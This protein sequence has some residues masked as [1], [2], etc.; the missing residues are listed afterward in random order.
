VTALRRSLLVFLCAAVPALGGNWPAW[1]GPAGDGHSSEKD[2]PLKW[3]ATENVRWKVP[4]PDEGNS[5][6]IVWSDRV[7]LTQATEKA[8]WPPKPPAGGP[9]SAHKR[10][11][12]CFRRADGK[13]LWQKDT[14]YKDKESTHS[15]NPFCSASPVTDGERVVVSHGSAGLFC[16]D[17]DGKELWHY[18]LGK[19]EHIWGNAS[20]PVLDGDLV[21]LWCGPCERQFLLAVNKRTGEKVWQHDEPGGDSGKKG[22][23]IGSWCTPLVARVGDHDEL[24]VAVPEKVKAFD[25]KTGKELWSCAGLGKLVYAS[26]VCSAD[27]IVVAL[28][29]FHG[30]ALAVRAGGKGDVTATHRLWHH[31]DKNPQRIGSPVIVGEHVYLI[32]EQGL[33]QCF[34]LKTGKELW[35]SERV[36]KPT[37]GSLV[38]AGGRLYVTNQTG[39]TVVLATNPKLE[40]LA[41]NR[42]GERMENGEMVRGS[43]AVSDGEVFIR[44]YKQLWCIGGNKTPGKE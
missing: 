41:R 10:S 39:E 4:L 29:G 35:N 14:I 26:P 34:E 6:P 23:W 9:A 31:A 16:Y 44:T 40:V 11:L 5:T 25:P 22:E 38:V 7:F 19:L 8:D 27:G 1:R 15:T 12:L 3:S 13:L 32:N 20:S 18:D 2:L 43:L 24:I 28:S 42:L 21:I 36:T 17:F 33:A 30:P 37:W